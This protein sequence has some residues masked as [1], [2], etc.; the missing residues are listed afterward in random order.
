MST[1]IEVQRDHE[2]KLHLLVEGYPAAGARVSNFSLDGAG[3][4]CAV[5]VIPLK[6]LTLG[7]IKNVV[8]FVRP[9]PN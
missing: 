7:E 9:Q 1:N 3:D 2:G 4:L 6:F 5:V 8:P